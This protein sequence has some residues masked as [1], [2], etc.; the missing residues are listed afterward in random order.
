MAPVTHAAGN[1][2]PI[3]AQDLW[4]VKRLGPPA[5]SPDG[6]RAVYSVQEWSI[7]K[8]KPSSSLWIT[9]VK[10]GATRRLTFQTG[11]DSAPDWSHDGTRIAFVSKRGE[12]EA[13]SLY[14]I[15]VAGGEA[16]KVLDLPYGIRAPRWLPNGQSNVFAT[17][18][19][20]SLTGKLQKNDWA[21]MKK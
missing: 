19:I 15:D 14:V 5:L 8:N 11:N 2:R 17:Q 4:A 21:A 9:E 12:D 20:P 3:T 1:P 13:A 16:E 18:V 6:K 10:T 7:E